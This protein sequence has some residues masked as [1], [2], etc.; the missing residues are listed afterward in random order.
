MECFAIAD[1]W[2]ARGAGAEEATK[3]SVPWPWRVSLALHEKAYDIA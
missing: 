3:K 2:F 1:K